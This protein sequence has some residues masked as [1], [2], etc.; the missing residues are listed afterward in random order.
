MRLALAATA[1]LAGL[2]AGPLAM[3]SADAQVAGTGR[4]MPQ[5]G[6]GAP[7]GA[8]AGTA[9][10]APIA[11]MSAAQQREATEKAQRATQERDKA[12]DTK[13]KRTMNSICHGC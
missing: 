8:A 9:A 6:A 10:G 13:T 1:A 2:L 5:P 11:G 12:W 7:A 4:R 3:S